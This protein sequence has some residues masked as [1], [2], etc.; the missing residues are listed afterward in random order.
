MEPESS[1]PCSQKPSTGPNPEPDQSSTYHASYLSKIHLVL[2]THLRPDLPSGLFPSGFPTNILSE[3]LFS[4]IRATC[5]AHLII[6]HLIIL[7]L[8]GEEHQLWSPLLRSFLQPLVTSSLLGPNILLS[9]LCSINLTS[10][11]E[12]FQTF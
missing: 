6:L 4:F 11:L 2:S 5:P 10:N 9:T 3:L 1:L 12:T 7:I 8:L